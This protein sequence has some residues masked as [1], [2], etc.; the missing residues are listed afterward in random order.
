MAIERVTAV[1]FVHQFQ[2]LYIKMPSC[3]SFTVV[4][5]HRALQTYWTE[6]LALCV[7]VD[8]ISFKYYLVVAYL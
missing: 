3:L 6:L 8:S 4:Y 5:L 7:L 2:T 1:A